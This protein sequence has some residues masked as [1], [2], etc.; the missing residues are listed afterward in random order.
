M[1]VLKNFL[2]HHNKVFLSLQELFLI[3][4]YSEEHQSQKST[5]N[6]IDAKCKSATKYTKYKHTSMNMN[7]LYM[8]LN[9]V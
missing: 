7:K 9:N 3:S 6:G 2:F 4:R 1:E 8:H 5:S